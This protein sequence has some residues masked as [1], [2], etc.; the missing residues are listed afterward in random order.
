MSSY[1][2]GDIVLVMISFDCY[3]VLPK[4]F[5]DKLMKNT[6]K[7]VFGFKRIAKNKE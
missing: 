7:R 5:W 3:F 6:K 2:Q 1:V 4:L